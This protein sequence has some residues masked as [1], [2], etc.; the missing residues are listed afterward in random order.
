M[1]QMR[2]F[3]GSASDNG[4]LAVRTTRVV[5]WNHATGFWV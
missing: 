1:L 5:S 4:A 3:A 2:A